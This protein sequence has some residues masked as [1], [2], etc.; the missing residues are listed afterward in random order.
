MLKLYVLKGF[1][2]R[3]PG[4]EKKVAEI[5][6]YEQARLRANQ[7]QSVQYITA[8]IYYCKYILQITQPSQYR[9]AELQYRYAVISEAPGM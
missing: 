2:S 8:N 6:D 3:A 7:V 9:F 5:V 1:C 4:C